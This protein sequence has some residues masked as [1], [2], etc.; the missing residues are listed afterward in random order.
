MT[1]FIFLLFKL[2]LHIVICGNVIL[3]FMK[4]RFFYLFVSTHNYHYQKKQQTRKHQRRLNNINENNH[5]WKDYTMTFDFTPVAPMNLFQL[6][7]LYTQTLRKFCFIMLNTQI[8]NV[9]YS[10]QAETNIFWN[11][12]INIP[13]YRYSYNGNKRV[14]VPHDSTN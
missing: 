13:Y 6:H 9:W 5:T 2:F 8:R 4:N 7:P 12:H 14:M 1:W 11:M 10:I 3:C